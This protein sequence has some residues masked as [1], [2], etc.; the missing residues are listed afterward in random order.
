MEGGLKVD[1]AR[2]FVWAVQNPPP[3]DLLC[4]YMANISNTADR[5]QD[6]L[7][8][9]LEEHDTKRVTLL[10]SVHD[11]GTVIPTIQSRCHERWC[12]GEVESPALLGV[13]QGISKTS[14]RTGWPRHWNPCVRR[15]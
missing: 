13:A 3:T 4:V 15:A 9:I 7:L 10:L 8:K 14:S 2:E 1:A 6:V 5:V 12:G 11:I